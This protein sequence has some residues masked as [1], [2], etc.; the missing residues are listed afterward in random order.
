MRWITT[1]SLARTILLAGTLALPGLA[2]AEGNWSGVYFGGGGG[3]ID[4]DPNDRTPK[5]L[6]IA[7]NNTVNIGTDD[8]GIGYYAFAGYRFNDYLGFE[9]GYADLGEVSFNGSV[10]P[11]A[12]GATSTFAI[13]SEIDGFKFAG[14]A[15]LPL[16]ERFYGMAKIGAFWWDLETTSTP[17][18]GA[19]PSEVAAFGNSES[20][21]STL[22]GF[23]LQYEVLNG[24]SVRLDFEH[25]FEVGDDDEIRSINQFNGAFEYRFQ[26]F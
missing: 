22:A 6:G 26:G 17:A 3:L 2:F 19:L 21:V 1:M 10:T 18:V 23:A 12:G 25:L 16:T 4:A 9:T 8:E 5:T 14:T 24:L 7:N 13:N 20:G 11:N 15:G